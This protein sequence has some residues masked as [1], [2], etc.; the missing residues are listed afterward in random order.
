MQ[1]DAGDRGQAGIIDL[2]LAQIVLIVD[3]ARAEDGRIWLL[4]DQVRGGGAAGHVAEVPHTVVR[5]DGEILPAGE[6]GVRL[7]AKS[8]DLKTIGASQ[9]GGARQCE[10]GKCSE[11]SRFKVHR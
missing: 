11:N 8:G 5:G 4:L 7:S 10:T 2:K 9:S 6:S 3:V 1:N